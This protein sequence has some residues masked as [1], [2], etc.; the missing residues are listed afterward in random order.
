VSESRAAGLAGGALAL[1]LAACSADG[2]G[3]SAGPAV[4]TVSV[5]LAG[6]ALGV[7]ET[8]HATVLLRDSSGAALSGRKVS[9]TSS[10]PAVASV[11]AAG[12]VRAL[13]L[14]SSEIRATSAKVTGSATL[15]VTS[16]P[17]LILLSASLSQ[18]VQSLDGSIPLVQGGH[19]VLLSVYGTLDRAFPASAP[20][21]RVRVE[22][23]VNGGRVLLDERPMTGTAA[24][25]P[26]SG[27]APLHQVVF[28]ASLVQPGLQLRVQ[29]NPD[30][31]P[32]ELTLSDNSFP[33]SGLPRPVP[34]QQV[35]PLQLTFVPILL[36]AGGSTGNVTPA[37]LPEYLYATFQ[38]HPVSTISVTIGDVL[39]S[40][41][42]FAGGGA[43]AWLSILQ[44]LDLR[45][46]LEGTGN[47]YVGVV[48]PPPGVSF[49]Q[50]GG[51]GYIPFDPVSSGPSTRTA[52]LVGVGW[53]NRARQTTEL[54]AHELA[55][56]MGRRHAPCGGA[57]AP[58]PLF[59]YPAGAIGVPGFDLYTYSLGGQALPLSFAAATSD[60][61]SYCTP[62]WISDYNYAG[63]LRARSGPVTAPAAASTRTDCLIVWGTIDGERIRLEPAFVVRAFPALPDRSG[64]FS[65]EG[66]TALGQVLF[67]LSFEPVQIDHAPGV[68]HFLFAVPLDP[69]V[70]AQLTA[71]RVAGGGGAAE[72]GGGVA[73]QLPV[74]GIAALRSDAGHVTLRWPPGQYPAVLVR[75]PGSR[76][77]LG[78][79]RSGSLRVSTTSSLLQ[80]ILSDGVRTTVL[81]LI[82]K[83]GGGQ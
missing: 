37:T 19:P 83:P 79:G 71:I 72:R 3:S 45:R 42:D 31:N 53:F 17:N 14:G 59:P 51:Y 28:P 5:S 73:L 11:S 35:P 30:S 9:W 48:R 66:R 54:V 32:H 70:L 34:V 69:A 18:A 47:Y 36:T 74:S 16:L 2:T 24:L 10:N 82:P 52:A 81:Q 46:V 41:V 63:L 26:G 25:P 62:V 27:T 56:T 6:P 75:D 55:H 49:V 4:A 78:M 22:F 64:R 15:H 40:D 29:L 58:D 20:V 61:M 39:A 76:T 80:V 7:G 65:L 21:P 8:T 1:A 50:F 23:F 57:A 43:A 12:T 67:R 60:I 13:A 77:L 68:R 33:A 38:L 44:L